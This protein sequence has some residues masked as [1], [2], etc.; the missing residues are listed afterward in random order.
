MNRAFTKPNASDLRLLASFSRVAHTGSMS[1]AAEELGYVASA[2][3]QHITALERSIGDTRLFARHPGSRL[4]LTAAGR[5]L[6]Q[7][8]DDLLSAAANFRDAARQVVGGEGVTLRVGAYG[9]ALAYLLPS[10]LSRLVKAAGIAGVETVELEPA[11]GLP[12]V[13]RGDL[14]VLIAHRYLPED[15]PTVRNATVIDLGDEP[16]VLTAS[17]ASN[18]RELA[19]CAGADWVAGQP[20]DVDRQLLSRWAA[21]SGLTPRVQHATADCHTAAELIASQFAVG[22]LPASV[23]YAPHLRDR[24]RTIDMPPGVLSPRRSVLAVSRPDSALPG[25]D[26]LV[27]ELRGLLKGY[28]PTRHELTPPH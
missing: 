7:P 26:L 4:T 6:I 3:S 22:L 24:L 20:K 11:D 2:V 21:E 23:A 14:D 28:E 25:I 9:T 10:I 27:N 19:D 8:A 1:R 15:D 12:L 17:A 5:G 18:L 13:E 16:I